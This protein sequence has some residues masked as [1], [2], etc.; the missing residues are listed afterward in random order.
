MLAWAEKKDAGK[1][2]APTKRTPVL[3]EE[4]NIATTLVENKKLQ[5][6]VIAH[7]VDPIKLLVFLPA[8][9]VL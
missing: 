6:I 4:V 2:D 8:C 9:P 1:G 3:L 7:D 5:L